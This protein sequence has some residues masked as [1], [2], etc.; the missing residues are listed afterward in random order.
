MER[1]SL[2]LLTTKTCRE[3]VRRTRRLTRLRGRRMERKVGRSLAKLRMLLELTLPWW[4]AGL[5]ESGGETP[6]APYDC[7]LLCHSIA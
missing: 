7:L 3:E 6:K 5:Y 2:R 1:L 4:Q